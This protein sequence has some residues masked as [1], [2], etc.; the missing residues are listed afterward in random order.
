MNSWVALLPTTFLVWEDQIEPQ[1]LHWQYLLMAA[2]LQET[3]TFK[4]PSRESNKA[5]G[6]FWIHWNKK[7]K[8]FFLQLNFNTEKLQALPSFPAAPGTPREAAPTP[9]DEWSAP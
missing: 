9:I 8:Q 2:K 7:T 5:R 3:I 4:V 6:K 1:D